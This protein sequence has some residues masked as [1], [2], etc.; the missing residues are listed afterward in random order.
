M[1]ARMLERDY[2]A[3][4]DLWTYDVGT[5]IYKVPVAYF[6]KD[7]DA[8]AYRRKNINKP[9]W[10][11]RMKQLANEF[12]PKKF[13]P[14]YYCKNCKRMEDGAR[15]LNYSELHNMEFI[16]VRI[17]DECYKRYRKRKPEVV[18]IA[19]TPEAC[20]KVNEMN[21]PVSCDPLIDIILSKM[22]EFPTSHRLDKKWLLAN[23]NDKWKYIEHVDFK[24]KKHSDIGC[25]VGYSCFRAWQ[26]GAKESCGLDIR[27][28]VLKVAEEVKKELNISDDE[29][30]FHKVSFLDVY[31]SHFLKCVINSDIVSMLGLIHYFPK[32]IYKKVLKS[33]CDITK[34]TLILELR[35]I[36]RN[37][38]FV[39]EIQRQ[40]LPSSKWL[41]N[42]L[43]QYGFK[44]ERRVKREFRRELWI[45][46]RI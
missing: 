3:N 11:A 16:S 15:R 13:K 8:M 29:G 7:K 40:T 9:W 41:S 27:E 36:D 34:E 43:K 46:K 5:I 14:I 38:P 45:A 42:A 18:G 22:K 30:T 4:T 10:K 24:D 23:V 31:D 28:D 37:K 2:I 19:V 26:K 21:K 25:H 39:Q 17:G 32:K 6:K 35:I 1:E 20:D 44:V 12:D 33:L